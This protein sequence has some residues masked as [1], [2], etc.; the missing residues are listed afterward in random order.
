MLVSK[1]LLSRIEY[2]EAENKSLKS[3]KSPTVGN[4]PFRVECIANDDKLIKL[5][6]YTGF[7]TYSV[8]VAFF[9]FLGPSV[10]ELTYWF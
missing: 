5:Y 7:T 1:V 9:T 6:V 4:A 3:K 8:F 10:N 2:L